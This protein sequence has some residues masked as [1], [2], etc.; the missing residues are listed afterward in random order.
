MKIVASV[1]RTFQIKPYANVRFFLGV[2]GQAED[3]S[4]V[5]EVGQ[6]LFDIAL[7]AIHSSYFRYRDR[8][9]KID[10][11][12]NIPQ[13]WELIKIRELLKEGGRNGSNY[14]LQKIKAF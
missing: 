11:Q 4:E 2:E 14:L 9:S 8:L 3:D 13:Q 1:E 7:D 6:E 10:K 12:E 5:K